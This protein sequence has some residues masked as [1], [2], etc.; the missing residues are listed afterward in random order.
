MNFLK[1]P[2]ASEQ[3]DSANYVSFKGWRSVVGVLLG[4]AAIVIPSRAQ[5]FHDIAAGNLIVVQIDGADTTNSV[6]VSMD[7]SV[8]D[9]RVRTNSNRGDYNVQ[10]GPDATDDMANGVLMA[11]V[12]Q[13]GRDNFNTGT[14]TNS[15]CM[16][17]SNTNGYFIS[18]SSA[19][20]LGGGSNPE[21]NVNVAGAYFPYSTWLGGVANNTANGGP[22][23]VFTGSPSLVLG[24]H[25][26]DNGSG[27]FVVDL[28]SL[29]IDSRTDGVLLV[30][31]AK[32]ESAN[33]GLSQ[34]NTNNGT[35]N[36]FIKDDGSTVATNTEQDPIAFVF[37]PKTNTSVISGRF[38]GDASID[39]FSG[40]SPQFTVSTLGTGRYELKIPGRSPTNGVLIISAEGGGATNIDNMVSYEVNAAQ[41]GWEIQ[42]RDTP[43]TTNAPVPLES[44]SP[45]EG[46][47]SFIY[48]PARGISVTGT[49]NLA[50]TEGGGTATFNVVLDTP[51][52]NTVTINVSSSNTAEGTVSP[53]SLVFD[54]SN[55]STP[56]TVTV[57]GQ[58]DAVNDG[59]I[60][61]TIVLSPAV[62]DDSN[63]N[64]LDAPDV[65]VF[66]GDNEGGVSVVPTTGLVTSEGGGTATFTVRLNTQPTADV[67]IN[68]SSS[69]TTEGTVSPSSFTFTTSNWDQ[70]QTA[71]V[72]GV[73]ASLDEGDVDYKKVTTDTSSDSSYNNSSVADVSVVNTDN[74]SSGVS[75]SPTTLSV[76]EGATNGYT[77]VLTAQPTA[78]VTVN[79]SST[80][81]VQGG[82]VSPAALTFTAANWNTPRT[83]VVTGSNDSIPDG[84]TAFRI[85]NAVS[86][87]DSLYAA[88]APVTVFVTTLDNEAVITLP[89]AGVFYGIGQSG[90][91]IDGRA[92]IVD[93]NTFN[94]SATTLTIAITNNGTTDDRLEIR[95]TGTGVGQVGVSG[96]TVSYEGNAIGTF[97]GGTGTTPLVITF[98]NVATPTSAQAVLRSVTFRNVNSNPS[99]NYRSIS[100]TLAHSDGGVSSASTLMRVSLLRATE[101]QEGADHGYGVYTG[102]A[103]LAIREADPNTPYPTGGGS[104]LFV[105]FPDAGSHNGWHVLMRFDN[106]FGNGPG[107]IPTNAIL[108]SADLL[109]HFTDNGGGTPLYRMIKSWDATSTTWSGMDNGIDQDDVD[110]RSTYDSFFASGLGGSTGT[111][112]PGT[113]SGTSVL[114]DIQAWLNGEVN[115]GWGM[116]GWIGKTDGTGFYPGETANIDERP[117]LRVTWV[118]AGTSV[119][120]FRDGVNG[121]TGQVDTFIRTS[122]PDSNYVANV[123]MFCDWSATATGDNDQLLF[124]FDNIVGSGGTNQIPA[125]SVIHAAMFD[126]GSVASQANGDGGQFFRLLQPWT[127]TTTTWN[128]WNNGIQNDGV[129]AAATATTIA[130]NAGLEPNV[131]AGY[132]SFEIT[133]DVQAWVNG[134]PNYGFAI[135]PWTNGGDGWAIATAE[136]ATERDRPQLR[137]FY[138]PNTNVVVNIQIGSISRTSSSVTI[139][140]T[141]APSTTY[142][143]QRTTTLGSGWGTIGSPTTSAGGA[144]SFTDNA[145]P[146]GAAFY[147]IAP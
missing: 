38:R 44:P 145:P 54:S 76:V 60:A 50:T 107:Q 120:T 121:Y 117:R 6:A 3:C 43:G 125:G 47:V 57:T 136:S 110:S 39:M 123:T 2:S 1:I 116:P 55:W 40:N 95:D 141:G 97:A 131:E 77:V 12:R 100:V 142:S 124:R 96:N 72:T 84:N 138:T 71:T 135:L 4:V 114:P 30:S 133:S 80:D 8:N 78:D 19:V 105:D 37:V 134:A 63:Y 65:T 52:T 69:D 58:D 33:F 75:I 90:V 103:D 56:Q 28:T 147:R 68:L 23:T 49:N 140:F 126:V 14:K 106:L 70:E 82:T 15:V 17:D 104:G 62:S 13:N 35:W 139:Q 137:I 32:N 101:F 93:P 108:V 132:Q 81:T 21:Y 25:F 29:G 102:E 111:N 79:I 9:F 24:T 98:N 41:D 83:V 119:A 144:A 45:T 73:N 143:V 16:I 20:G 89:S 87:V 61:Y 53:S 64:N 27:R 26:I 92:S 74:D 34:P 10:I 94:Y 91:G 112:A 129:E 127:D 146:A 59:P 22:L 88:L 48:I 130:G 36:L 66:N 109:L 115:N 31:G 128:T 46:V 67:T 85:T 113:S 118:P 42:S 99:V 18:V 51:P 5:S 7:Y 122:T 86:S 11:S